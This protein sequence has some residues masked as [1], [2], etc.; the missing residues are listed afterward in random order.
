MTFTDVLDLQLSS[1]P[2]MLSKDVTAYVDG[3]GIT[4][5]TTAAHRYTCRL[6]ELLQVK[7]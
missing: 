6:S 2:S 5:N 3:A 1:R 7:L 4:E